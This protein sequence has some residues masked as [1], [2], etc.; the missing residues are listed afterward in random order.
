MDNETVI[1][2]KEQYNDLLQQVA[3]LNRRVS[4][5]NVIEKE[6]TAALESLKLE[7]AKEQAKLENII[8]TS[9]PAVVDLVKRIKDNVANA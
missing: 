7:I 3:F 1:T 6:R 5:L 2:T 9:I 8:N 4:D